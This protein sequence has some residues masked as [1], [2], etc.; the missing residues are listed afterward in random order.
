MTNTLDQLYNA[1]LEKLERIRLEVIEHF[2]VLLQVQGRSHHLKTNIENL[3][4]QMSLDIIKQASNQTNTP[5]TTSHE[6]EEHS[7]R[8]GQTLMLLNRQQ[9]RQWNESSHHVQNIMVT[10]NHIIDKLVSSVNELE[11]YSTH[12]P[13][14]GLH[15]RRYFTEILEYETARSMRHHYPFS[16]LLIDLDN[17]KT[18]NDTYGHFCG[19]TLL[20]SLANILRAYLR[21]GDIISRIGGDEFA[22]ILTETIAENA[23]E[24]AEL[25]RKMVSDTVFEDEQ[26]HR[27]HITISIGVVTYP[28]DATDIMELLSHVDAALY[29]AKEQGRNEV[30]LFSSLM[31]QM[32]PEKKL[33][34]FIEELR[35]AIEEKRIVPYFQPIVHCASNDI[36]GYEVLARLKK[37]NGEIVPA[38][39]FVDL[40]ESHGLSLPFN[41]HIL[42]QTLHALK[43]HIAAN[44]DNVR[45]FINISARAI[46]THNLI[47]FTEKACKAIGLSTQSLVF[48]ILERDAIQD[49]ISMR[50]LLT[51]MRARGFAFALDDFGSGFNS[52]HYLHEMHFDF[53]KIAGS[54]VTDILNST[55]DH[56]LVRH[57][58]RLCQELHIMTI[59]ES[60]ESAEILAELKAIGVDCAQGAAMGLPQPMM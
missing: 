31:K 3:I 47:D 29:E 9:E 37:E 20:K 42:L 50:E 35:T 36:L 30:I 27:Y 26:G 28:Q 40:I 33:K 23:R 13:L 53:I 52:F 39:E 11:F 45:V 15:N 54:F 59:A 10:F 56:A 6:L 4:K 5:E 55:V 19:D 7:K 49:I 34:G 1:P 44:K 48:E 18:V 46:L 22:I 8:L 43:A 12:D 16:V 24:L 57:I 38:V 41:Q 2:S 17:F 25:L 60:V 58:C 14:T 21:K 32:F 51:K